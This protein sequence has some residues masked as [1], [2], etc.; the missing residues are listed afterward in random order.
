MRRA[1][2]AE[3]I[4]CRDNRKSKEDLRRIAPGGNPLETPR[5]NLLLVFIAEAHD[6]EDAVL[7]GLYELK[8]HQLD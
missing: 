4:V 3:T 8:P 5:S 1:E 2:A 7:L 6:A